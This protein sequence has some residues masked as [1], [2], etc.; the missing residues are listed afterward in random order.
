M[1]CS[2]DVPEPTLSEYLT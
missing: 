1:L 2:I